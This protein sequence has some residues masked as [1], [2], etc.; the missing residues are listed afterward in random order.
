MK[1][2]THF[3]WPNRP[4]PRRMAY[5]PLL[6][7]KPLQE[8]KGI[9]LQADI[10]G[11]LTHFFEGQTAPCF[12]GQIFCPGCEAGRPVRWKGY[13][14]VLQWL[15]R[16]PGLLELTEEAVRTNERL[17]VGGSPLTGM[18][19]TARRIGK[20][21]NSPVRVSFEDG[22]PHMNLP[23]PFDVHTVL[24]AIWGVALPPQQ[25]DYP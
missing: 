21:K 12:K 14:P 8:V 4:P 19:V 9:V 17:L 25:E 20:Q 18:V 15:N 7:P 24:L 6:S 10:T 3:Q 13:L 5:I 23:V 16:K 22:S 11:V 1:N 2:L